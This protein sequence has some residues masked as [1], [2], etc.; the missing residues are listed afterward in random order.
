MSHQEPRIRRRPQPDPPKPP[1]RRPGPRVVI[2]GSLSLFAVLFTL[3]TFQL[4]AGASPARVASKQTTATAKKP[5]GSEFAETTGTD[6]E[7]T[8]ETESG[9]APSEEE[10]A[11]ESEELESAEAEAAELEAAAEEESPPV[12][13]SAS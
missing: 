9:S 8:S 12:V 7:E 11:A 4:S 2:W 13:T 6:A 1:T 3:L 10:F 5:A